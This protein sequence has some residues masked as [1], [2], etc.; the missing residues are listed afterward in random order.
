MRIVLASS[1]KQRQDILKMIGLKY[2]VVTS[3]VEEKSCE[4]EPN[5]YV[6]DLSLVKAESV[7]DQINDNAI[8]IAADTV[9]TLNGK[10]YEKPKN[11]Q[12]ARNNLNELSGNMNTAWTAI[13]II[14]SYKNK[15]ITVSNKTNIYFKTLTDT[16]IEWYLNSEE[17][18]YKCCGYVPLG[19]ASLFIE[20]IDGDYNNLLGLSPYV[21]FS[22]FKQ[23]GYD[24][25]ELEFEDRY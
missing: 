4:I 23:L 16:E 6:E 10:I 21:V 17:K 11:L 14:D 15:T 22:L 20:K 24:V 9:I 7:F 18:I 13:T 1:S 12:E 8:I 25:N 5:K 19:K 3:D 2:E